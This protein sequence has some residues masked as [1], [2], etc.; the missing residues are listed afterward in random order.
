MLAG[1]NL[2]RVVRVGDTVRRVAGDWTPMV[3]DLLRHIRDNGFALAPEPRGLDEQGREVLSFLPGDTMV[4]HPWPPWVWRDD[5]LVQAARALASYH[6]A[7]AGFRPEVVPSRLGTSVL[8]A[9]DIVCH[10]DFA[11]YNCTFRSGELTGVFDWDLIGAA[12]PLW[13][14]GFFAWQWLPLHATT[15]ELAWRTPEGLAGRLRLLVDAYGLEEGDGLVGAVIDRIDA[16][17][18]GVVE[19]AAAGEETFRRLEREGHADEMS[20]AVDFVRSLQPTLE[21]A[22]AER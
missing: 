2:T 17:R 1:G 5:L 19:R 3:H 12:P 18:A 20:R 8:G 14:L 10:N 22:L 9:E 4:H 11:P 21:R 6:R 13:D 16:S 7:V 15:E